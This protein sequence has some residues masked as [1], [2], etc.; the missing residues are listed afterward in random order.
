MVREGLVA[1]ARKMRTDPTSAE[2]K[3]WQSL[4]KRQLGG[5]KFRRQHIIG[6][7]IVDFYCPEGKLI[8]EVDG[9][10]HEYQIQYDRERKDDLSA[11]GYKVVRFKNEEIIEDLDLVLNTILEILKR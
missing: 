6:A 1:R 8:V 7:Y 9:P 10:V 2:A 4:R 11:M 5:L 3:F